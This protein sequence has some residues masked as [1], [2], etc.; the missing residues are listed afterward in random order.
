MKRKGSFIFSYVI[1]GLVIAVGLVVGTI[2]GYF[3]L[4]V[5]QINELTSENTDLKEEIQTVEGELQTTQAS[6]EQA[7]A[8]IE[9]LNNDIDNL[10]EE[11]PILQAS[12]DDYQN[13]IADLNSMYDE[14]KDECA[15]L[16]ESYD[17]LTLTL[18]EI[19]QELDDLTE[20]N[21][22]LSEQLDY[23]EDLLYDSD[24]TYSNG[25]IGK[26]LYV[27]ECPYLVEED[28]EFDISLD[29]E[30]LD[31]ISWVYGTGGRLEVQFLL[32]GDVEET[33]ALPTGNTW[34]EGDIEDYTVSFTPDNEG[35]IHLR[36]TMV[37][38]VYDISIEDYWWYVDRVM[39]PIAQ[40]VEY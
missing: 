32:D 38:W 29:F 35:A 18:N 22:T 28:E 39:I 5:P 6:L 19:E 20:S 36:I 25:S 31:D 30:A 7:Q 4:G 11:I 34:D 14:L 9:D 27:L 13:E 23:L 12:V 3:V 1:W 33:E 37:Y 21:Q 16:Q 26:L 15:D 8:E 40:S 10:Q 24:A 2:V 17:N